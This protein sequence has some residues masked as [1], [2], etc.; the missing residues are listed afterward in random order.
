MTDKTLLANP[1]LPMTAGEWR[2]RLAELSRDCA[3]AQ[4][5]DEA[6]RLGTA[7]DLLMLAPDV[8]ELEDITCDLLPRARLDGLLAAGAHDTAALALMPESASYILSRSRAGGALASVLL[9]GMEDD[10]TSQGESVAMALISALAACLAALADGFA[11][12][13]T[14]GPRKDTPV[15]RS[16]PRCGDAAFDV[17][18]WQVPSGTLLN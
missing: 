12:H 3:V 2:L 16:A 5:E 8:P 11:A 1:T 4:P 13:Q 9:T 17:E 6:A 18:A 10:L 14:T 15:A 7:H